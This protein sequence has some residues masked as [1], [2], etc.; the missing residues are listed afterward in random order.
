[1]R[2]KGLRETSLLPEGEAS[3]GDLLYAIRELKQLNINAVSADYRPADTRWSTLC[4]RF[5]LYVV[6]AE[7]LDPRDTSGNVR[8]L[9]HRYRD[10][11]TSGTPDNLQ[12]TNGCSFRDLLD[13]RMRWSLESDNKGTSG[14]GI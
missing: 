10:I 7:W 9:R 3:E 12:V 8:E 2:L 13:V 6:P 14:R 11:R 1:M 4:D 5:G